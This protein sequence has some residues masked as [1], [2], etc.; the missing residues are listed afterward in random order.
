MIILFAILV[1]LF[2]YVVFNYLPKLRPALLVKKGTELILNGNHKEGLEFFAK[3]AMS[4]K[5]KPYTKVRYAF[6]ELKYG[7]LKKAKKVISLIINDSFADRKVKCEA[8]GVWALISYME[9][10]MEQALEVCDFLYKNYKNTDVYCTMGYIYNLAKSPEEAVTFNLEAY[11]YNP[12]KAVISDNLGQAYYL[13]GEY[14]KAEELYEKIMKN[15]PNFPEAYYNYAL[16]LMK[17]GDNE[18]A[19]QMLKEALN[20]EFHNLT[21]VSYDAVSDTLKSLEGNE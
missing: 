15:P 18:K 20:K 17:K 13:N 6:L 12:D 4:P 14:E 19:T 3:G 10:D 16:V 7:E 2:F 21:T 9:G 5:M 8:K 1:F 11:G